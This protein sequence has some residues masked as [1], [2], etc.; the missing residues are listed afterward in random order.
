MSFKILLVGESGVGKTTLLRTLKCGHF[1]KCGITVGL[2]FTMHHVKM[3]DVVCKLIIW[4]FGGCKN[5][6]QMYRETP[7]FVEGAHGALLAF[8]ISSY[9]TL[10]AL[11]DWIRLIKKYNPSNIPIILV[12]MKADLSKA[13]S[14]DEI[15][16]FIEKHQIDDYIETSALNMVNVEKPFERIVKMILERKLAS[17]EKISPRKIKFIESNETIIT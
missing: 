11:K 16:K 1:M 9:E 4:D 15:A 3:D 7:H 17:E 2:D 13:V 5:F 10:L 12:G 6:M 8:D 14:R